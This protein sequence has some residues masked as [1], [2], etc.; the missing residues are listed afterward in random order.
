MKLGEKHGLDGIVVEYTLKFDNNEASYYCEFPKNIIILRLY[1]SLERKGSIV[2]YNAGV[3]Y[4]KDTFAVDLSADPCPKKIRIGI[5]ERYIFNSFFIKELIC[6]LLKEQ[7]FTSGKI[8]LENG[9]YT[10]SNGKKAKAGNYIGTGCIINKK[11]K[12]EFQKRF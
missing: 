7:D 6:Y 1:Q 11:G 8:N 5:D 12:L 3:G 9:I 2:Y 10:F 4:T